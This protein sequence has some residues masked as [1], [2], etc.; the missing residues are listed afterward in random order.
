MSRTPPPAVLS[1]LT[2]AGLAGPVRIK[3][4]HSR[5]KKCM[6]PILAA[7]EYFN[8]ASGGAVVVDPQPITIAAEIQC[9]L[10]GINTFRHYRDECLIR[11]GWG[12]YGT[13]PG[14]SDG[15]HP[16]HICGITHPT[17]T[18][19]RRRAPRADTTGPAPF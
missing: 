8:P 17:D 19:A 6:A 14:N 11:R 3:P 16:L 7:L 1:R 5:C 18:T 13:G 10:V 15:I 9:A 4:A 12:N 2:L